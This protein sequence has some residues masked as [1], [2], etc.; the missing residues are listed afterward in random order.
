MHSNADRSTGTGD[1]QHG[2]SL[3]YRFIIEIN[4]YNCIGTKYRG[5]TFHF[6]QRLVFCI[7]QQM[8]LC[9]AT[10]A[11]EVCK[12][13]L[14]VSEKVCAQNYFPTYNSQILLNDMSLELRCCRK[15]HNII[16][17]IMSV[18]RINNETPHTNLNG[19][20]SIIQQMKQEETPGYRYVPPILCQACTCHTYYP[21]Q[22]PLL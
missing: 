4:P 12:R 10:S 17:K 22:P 21:L 6:F 19:N 13:G 8:F 1:H 3:P 14:K 9:T 2:L 16:Y 15:Y 7:L 11:K 20:N 18:R 5:A